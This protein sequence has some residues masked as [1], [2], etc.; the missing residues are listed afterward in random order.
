MGAREWL[1]YLSLG[2]RHILK[3]VPHGLQELHVQVSRPIDGDLQEAVKY[4]LLVDLELGRDILVAVHLKG[5]AHLHL[6]TC[7]AADTPDGRDVL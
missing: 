3:R 1:G 2:C 4:G 5:H 7:P 6:C